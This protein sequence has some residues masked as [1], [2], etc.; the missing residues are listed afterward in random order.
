MFRYF[1]RCIPM[2]SHCAFV[3]VNALLALPFFETQNIDNTRERRGWLSPAGVVEVVTLFDDI[4]IQ[5]DDQPSATTF[6]V[7]ADLSKRTLGLFLT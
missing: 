5:F 3:P 4:L 6:K 1:L 2:G 7:L